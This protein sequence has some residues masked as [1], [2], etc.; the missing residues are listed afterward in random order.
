MAIPSWVW[1]SGIGIGAWILLSSRAAAASPSDVPTRPRPDPPVG[2]PV[3]PMLSGNLTGTQFVAALT[4][5]SEAQRD[6]EVLAAVERGNTPS[7]LAT[8]QP[9]PLASGALRATAYVAPDFLGVGTDADWVRWPVKPGLAQRLADAR[10]AVLPT[11]RIADAIW[12]AS[13]VKVRMP[14]AASDKTALAT[15]VRTSRSADTRVA[16]RA[17]L[18]DGHRKNILAAD[19]RHPRSVIIYGASNPD[20]GAFP[21]QPYSWV[22]SDQYFDYSHG[23]RLVAPYLD[24]AGRGRVTMAQA[25]SDA[26]LAPLV[27]DE[28]FERSGARYAG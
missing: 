18:I 28:A 13:D 12:A 16:G 27:S 6:A 7:P 2:P 1:V 15:I 26:T 22:H 23:V 9:V 17:G 14:Y 3:N 19:A 20:S 4:P 21:L 5:M 24:V 8:W 11:R 25:L 10:G